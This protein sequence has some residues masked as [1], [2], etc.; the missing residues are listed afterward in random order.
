MLG[1]A[2]LLAAEFVLHEEPV[3]TEAAF[4]AR[5]GF[6][7]GCDLTGLAASAEKTLSLPVQ[8]LRP[9]LQ[10]VFFRYVETGWPLGLGAGDGERPV[11]LGRKPEDGFTGLPEPGR[12]ARGYGWLRLGR[13]R[14][15]FLLEGEPRA[16]GE[17]RLWI[18]K[19]G[20][21]KDA[22]PLRN[23]GSPKDKAFAAPAVLSLSY[24]GAGEHPIILWVFSD[25]KGERLRYYPVSHWRAEVESAAGLRV[26]LALFDSR[27]AGDYSMSPM[28]VA[29]PSRPEGSFDARDPSRDIYWKPRGLLGVGRALRLGRETVRL[30]AVSPKGDWADVEIEVR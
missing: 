19:G 22:A 17:G 18:A 21:F 11:K 14:F 25:P 7:T 13:D 30:K 2:L 20:D 26:R 6:A 8:K 16:W 4:L 10:R 9:G 3:T 23:M 5:Y 15:A 28:A 24:P 27:G 29:D 1:L 12:G